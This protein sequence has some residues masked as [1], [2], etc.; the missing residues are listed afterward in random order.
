MLFL[1]VFFFTKKPSSSFFFWG[2]LLLN[3]SAVVEFYGLLFLGGIY[4]F[5]PG[6]LL[7]LLDISRLIYFL[8]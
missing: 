6:I 8:I 3:V 4:K 2:Y 5:L 7:V 1:S